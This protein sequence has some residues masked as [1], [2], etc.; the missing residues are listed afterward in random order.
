[1]SGI[2]RDRIL[3]GRGSL[4]KLRLIQKKEKRGAKGLNEAEN[5]MH[6]LQPPGQKSI[7]FDINVGIYLV[8]FVCWVPGE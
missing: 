8:I 7:G 5:V 4:N 2:G 1:M 6:L 3:T